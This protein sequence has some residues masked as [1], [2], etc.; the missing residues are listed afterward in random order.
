[1]EHVENQLDWLEE[2]P[3]KAHYTSNAYRAGNAPLRRIHTLNDL[4][5]CDFAKPPP[6]T[7]IRINPTTVMVLKDGF[8]L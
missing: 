5:T 4:S 3:K 7:V 8:G 6:F 1:M 2:K